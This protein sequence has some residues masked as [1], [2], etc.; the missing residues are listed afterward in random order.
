MPLS[1]FWGGTGSALGTVHPLA[2]ATFA[3]FVKECLGHP[4]VVA[5]ISR[6][7]FR[8]LPDRERNTRKRVNWFAPA[9][10][11]SRSR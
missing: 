3:S 11:R 4:A 7:E 10:F 5:S 6:E 1:P 9:V 2:V 8:A